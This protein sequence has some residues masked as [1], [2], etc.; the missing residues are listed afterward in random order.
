MREKYHLLKFHSTHKIKTYTKEIQHLQERYRNMQLKSQRWIY[1][2]EIHSLLAMQLVWLKNFVDIESSVLLILPTDATVWCC[3]VNN[4][5]T[6][7]NVQWPTVFFRG[8]VNSSDEGTAEQPALFEFNLYTAWSYV[9]ANSAVY[10]DA[11]VAYKSHASFI[12]Y[13]YMRFFLPASNICFLS[14]IVL[15]ILQIYLECDVLISFHNQWEFHYNLHK[16]YIHVMCFVF[17]ILAYSSPAISYLCFSPLRTRAGGLSTCIFHLW[18]I[19]SWLF[20]NYISA[21]AFSN[22]CDFSAPS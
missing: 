13:R 5:N 3:S 15:T 21:F 19:M 12:S 9:S 14:V 4:R 22:T 20:C 6:I 18:C 16:L 7:G 8:T 10:F 17:F 1:D 2:T 11:T